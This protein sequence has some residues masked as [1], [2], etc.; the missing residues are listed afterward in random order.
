MLL[1]YRLLLL[2][3]TLKVGSRSLWNG[4]VPYVSSVCLDKSRKIS[5]EPI[6]SSLQVD[7]FSLS[8]VIFLLSHCQESPAFDP[9]LRVPRPRPQGGSLVTTPTSFSSSSSSANIR[10]HHLHSSFSQSPSNPLPPSPSS[11][12]P[13]TVEEVKRLKIE[14]PLI[15]SSIACLYGKRGFPKDYVSMRS[16]EV[17]DFHLCIRA[18]TR[19]TYLDGLSFLCKYTL[20]LFPCASSL[21][22]SSPQ[23]WSKIRIYT[24]VSLGY[25][26]MWYR[27]AYEGTSTDSHPR[28]KSGERKEELRRLRSY[29][30]Y[31]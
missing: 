3:S 30:P 22:P 28:Y 5:S 2:L 24:R 4:Q 25:M 23:V 14:T 13:L 26:S 29:C 12:K 27:V 1:L 17:W 7:S 6:H 11:Q 10:S 20:G 19:R 18:C 15:S 16:D 21:T 9:S 8:P 31:T